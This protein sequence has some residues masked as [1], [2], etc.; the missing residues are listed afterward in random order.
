MIALPQHLVADLLAFR[1]DGFGLA[2]FQGG[3]AGLGIHPGD[4][5]GD[6]L[7]IAALELL[8]LL[9]ALGL[10]DAPDG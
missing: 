7:L 6:Q 5:G 3:G 9:A 1:Q 8:H 10:A 2:D 4:Q